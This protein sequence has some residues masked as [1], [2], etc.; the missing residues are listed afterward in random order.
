MPRGHKRARERL[1]GEAV[2]IYFPYEDRPLLEQLRD[3]EE[4]GAVPSLSRFVVE[5]VRERLATFTPQ[6]A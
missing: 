3:W 4:K 6:E 5:A 2:S 1:L